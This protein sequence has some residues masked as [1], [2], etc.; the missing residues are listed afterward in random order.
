MCDEHDVGAGITRRS[1]TAMGAAATL[2]ACTPLY[3]TGRPLAE[4]MVEVPTQL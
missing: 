3:A 4:Q 1:F 2:A